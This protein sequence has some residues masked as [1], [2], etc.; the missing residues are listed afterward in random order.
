[1]H[2]TSRGKTGRGLVV[3]LLRCLFVFVFLPFA[4]VV[5]G[6]SESF[7]SFFQHILSSWWVNAAC[8]LFQRRTNTLMGRRLTGEE[9][10]SMWSA[11]VLSRAGGL[12]DLASAHKLSSSL[13]CDVWQ[14]R[15]NY[16]V[17]LSCL[18]FWDCYWWTA[19]G[20]LGNTRRGGPDVNTK[21]SGRDDFS[22]R[23]R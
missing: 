5:V 19:G 7:K 14:L 1:M 10:L 6:E 3:L 21:Y 18:E 15:G 23:D 8:C 2:S 4:A 16:T 9:F 12:A 20:G 13:L 11:V 17:V 22:A